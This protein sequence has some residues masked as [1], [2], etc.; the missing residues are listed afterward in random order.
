MKK[1]IIFAIVI[2]LG[3]LWFVPLIP[4]TRTVEVQCVI[5]PCNPI[6]E[7]ANVTLKDIAFGTTDERFDSKYR[8][9]DGVINQNGEVTT[10]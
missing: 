3:I 5:T 2:I 4:Q 10:F 1:I 6:V 7:K 8:N 9:I